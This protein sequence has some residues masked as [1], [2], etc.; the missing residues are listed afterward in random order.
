M[1][2]NLVKSN[3]FDCLVK[4]A[5]NNIIKEDRLS[6]K[7]ILDLIMNNINNKNTI[8]SDVDTILH[9]FI[10]DMNVVAPK[11]IYDKKIAKL[12]QEFNKIYINDI[13]TS[14][15]LYT[16]KPKLTCTTLSNIIHEKFGKFTQMKSV[17]TNYEY[18]ISYNMRILVTI[19]GLQNYKKINL[20]NVINPVEINNNL[21][22]PINIEIIDTY[23]KL[24]LLNYYNDWE[25][26]KIKEK[27]L[28]T[29]YLNTTI[30]KKTGGKCSTCKLN[31]NMNINSIKYL[32]LDLFNNENY[33]FINEWA[34][35]LNK[36]NSLNKSNQYDN[37]DNIIS[38]I[39]E[40][41]IENDNNKIVNYL[42]KFTKYGIFYK[43]NK[44][45]IPNSSRL[46]LY[47]FY[48]KFPES[49]FRNK[50]STIDKPFLEIYNNGSYEL[51]PYISIKY[52][53]NNDDIKDS[54]LTLKIGN[55]Y[56]LSYFIFIR[57]WL[58]KLLSCLNLI[59][60]EKQILKYKNYESL[61]I[62]I[63]NNR[64][65]YDNTQK[66]IGINFDEK[67][68]KKI[69]ISKSDIIKKNYYPELEMKKNN[70]YKILATS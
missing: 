1:F 14:I 41:S 45:Y 38:I 16:N 9:S 70:N 48:I 36:S 5:S 63:N 43:K 44:L 12:I 33:V 19:Y 51:V 18:T 3:Y 46:C 21:Y 68:D 42:S 26:L 54:F 37:F 60:P 2:G 64:K 55:Y 23:H 11:R 24:F 31:K 62:E 39:S 6:Y 10:H 47:T 27:I 4:E 50:I 28:Y 8:I 56:V 53:Y 61:L 29:Y 30:K 52:N 7:P 65:I 57:I 17:I 20:V 69:M 22:L 32:L 25:I 59:K 49:G 35:Y 67:I 40:N 34:V 58:V 15:I 66:F 13:K